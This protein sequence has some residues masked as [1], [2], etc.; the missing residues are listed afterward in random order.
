MCPNNNPKK[1]RMSTAASSPY[2]LRNLATKGHKRN[3]NNCNCFSSFLLC[4][5]CA[6]LWLHYEEKS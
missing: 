5:F 2:S 1:V 4:S 3:T 6:F